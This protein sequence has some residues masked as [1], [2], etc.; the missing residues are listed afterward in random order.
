MLEDG[1]L[2]GKNTLGY[3]SHAGIKLRGRG[4]CLGKKDEDF[5]VLGQR[6]LAALWLQIMIQ[7]R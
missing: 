3:L 4:L 2:L 7:V 6:K 1:V 5:L